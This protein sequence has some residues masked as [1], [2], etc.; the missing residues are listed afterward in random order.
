MA[1]AATS[2]EHRNGGDADVEQRR[3]AHPGEDDR[4]GKRQLDAQHPAA[5]ADA[6]PLGRLDDRGVDLAQAR[7]R[8]AHD[9]QQRVEEQRHDRSGVADADQRDE[10]SEQSQRG[11]GQ[12]RRGGVEDDRP[13]QRHPM[14]DDAQRDADEDGGAHGDEDDLDVLE[15]LTEQCVVVLRQVLG[16]AHGC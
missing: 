6:H 15:R 16:E 7:G 8:V 11:D 13:Q 1:Q 5:A 9:G 14:G 4:P 12:E 3:D 10:Q 2:H